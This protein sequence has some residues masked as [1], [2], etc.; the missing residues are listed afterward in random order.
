MSEQIAIEVVEGVASIEAS[1]W[2]RL[3]SPND[4]FT[5]HAFLEALER[6][7][8]VGPGTGWIPTHV[9]ARRAGTLVGAVPLYLKTDS[10][11]EYIFD[12]GWA[13]AAQRAGIP[14]YPKLVSAVPFTPATGRRLLVEGDA[15]EGPVFEALVGGVRAVAEHVGAESI[16]FLFLT[17]AEREALSRVPDFLPRLTSQFHWKSAGDSTYEEH[18][19]RLRS[20]ARK[21]VRRER[22]QAAASG[23]NLEV[24]TG[25]ALQDADWEALYRFYRSTTAR[26]GAIDYLTEGFFH[27]IRET[28]APHVVVALARDGERPVAG[29]L[30]FEKGAH[31][32]GRYWGALERHEGL[33]FEL[34]YHALIERA[35]ER[36]HL[37]FEAGAQ[38]AHKIQ[39]GLLPSA[40]HS[41][42][43]LR[44]PGLRAAVADHLVHEIRATREEMAMLGAR[45]PYKRPN[46]S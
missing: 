38:G 46:R 26:K 17:R 34:C 3:V 19:S 41:V 12:W 10:Y 39:R 28:F 42:H 16:H 20:P 43:W 36:G 7:G 27:R 18:L 24:C 23:L 21:Q 31:L 13:G 9:L 33:H 37:R 32:Y 5:D 44:H 11:G 15:V 35:V 2:N 40:T 14:Y 29:S 25:D 45:T 6:S 30:S 8:S 22:R 4:P 1:E